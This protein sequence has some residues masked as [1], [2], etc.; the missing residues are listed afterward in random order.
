MKLWSIFFKAIAMVSM[1]SLVVMIAA[2]KTIEVRSG[3][4]T[5]GSGANWSEEYRISAI[6]PEGKKIISNRLELTGDRQHCGAWAECRLIT[7]TDSLVVWGVKLQGHNEGKFGPFYFFNA[8]NGERDSEAIVT[9]E[10]D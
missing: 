9:I 3:Q 10:T 8:N 6:A 1:L 2:A 4:K 5:S 7:Q